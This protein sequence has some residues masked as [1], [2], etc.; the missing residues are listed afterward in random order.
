MLQPRLL[1]DVIYRL[2]TRSTSKVANASENINYCNL[3]QVVPS[4]QDFYGAFFSIYEFPFLFLLWT[5]TSTC[6]GEVC[7]AGD[8]LRLSGNHNAM[9]WLIF[10]VYNILPQ[11]SLL[12]PVVQTHKHN[13]IRRRV[14]TAHML[15]SQVSLTG[16]SH[17]SLS[18]VSLTG[19]YL[20]S[21]SQVSIKGLFHRSLSQ[22]SL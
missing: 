11:I 6:C 5:G 15:L 22:F 21:L 12:S 8:S 16:L 3:L 10:I 19:L 14:Q 18:Q 9:L 4:L 13:T 2:M 1:Y 20:R 7:G 17:R